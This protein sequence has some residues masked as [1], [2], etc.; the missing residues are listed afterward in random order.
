MNLVRWLSVATVYH[1]NLV[2]NGTSKF[3][4]FLWGSHSTLSLLNMAPQGVAIIGGGIFVK[5]EHLVCGSPI[6]NGNR[7]EV[8]H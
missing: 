8:F 4:E 6:E 1:S 5:E 7:C 3:R 2:L